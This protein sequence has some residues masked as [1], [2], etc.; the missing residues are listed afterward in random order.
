MSNFNMVEFLAVETREEASE[1]LKGFTGKELKN[2]AKELSIPV[3]G[4]K[5]ADMIN[6]IVEM[7]V[8]FKIRQAALL[9]IE[10]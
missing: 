7:T 1:M 8:G 3:N 2:I 10:L 5:K 4:V 6:K 9:S